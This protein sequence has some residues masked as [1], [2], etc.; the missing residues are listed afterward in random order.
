VVG[1]LA[2]GFNVGLTLTE[3]TGTRFTQA[4]WAASL[5]H[6]LSE[7]VTVYAEVFGRGPASLGGDTLTAADT[8]VL[9][10]INNDLQF[11]VSYAHGLSGS[12]LDHSFGLGLSSRF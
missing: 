2:L 4:F 6:P 8:G 3:D 1:D 9:L 12:G 11:D 10:L 5:S 7:Q